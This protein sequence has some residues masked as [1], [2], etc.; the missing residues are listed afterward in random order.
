MRNLTEQE[1]QELQKCRMSPV[2]FLHNYGQILDP[3]LGK[4][5]FHL[6]EYQNICLSKFLENPLN[7]ILKSRQ[8]G[9]SWL[10]AGY[11]LWLSMFFIDK[12][13]LMISIKDE[14]AKGLLN[15]VYYIWRHLPDF[16]QIEISD[17]NMSLIR[18]CTGS[19]IKSVPTS[20]E[21][22][23]SE[24][25]SLL[26]MDE[27]A[28]IR[29]IEQIWAAAYP[30]LS[31]GGQCIV[32]STPN[33]MGN[34][35]YELWNDAIS[36]KNFFN[37][38]R[39]NWWYH[40]ERDAE[41]YDAQRANMSSVQFAQEVIGDFI[42]SGNLVFDVDSLRA[43]QEECAMQEVLER[44][45]TEEFH[46]KEKCG[47]YIYEQARSN[48]DYIMSID[49]AAGGGSGDLHAAH[50][51]AMST[52]VQVAEYQS[53]APIRL[54]N[55]RALALGTKYNYALA[56]PEV[57]QGGMGVP[58]LFHFQDNYYP[59]IYQYVNPLKQGT[60]TPGFPTNSLTRPLLIEEL[61]TSIREGVSGVRGIR[62]ANQLL[63]FAWSKKNKPEAMQGH[64]DDLVM[65]Y[66]IG[67]YVRKTAS[68]QG[69]LPMI[70]S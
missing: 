6:Y 62:T 10:V 30:T 61:D 7:I 3:Y 35:Y 56:A 38:I 43:L 31:T 40:P 46:P 41:W 64:H 36:G 16:L 9:L 50:I 42:A 22:G 29:W 23:R 19:E 63:S 47:L 67:R 69:S 49:T 70:V 17:K 4:I 60:S 65:S 25:L 27:A 39:L 15:K 66:G 14:T 21:A 59:N 53:N 20:E 57:I 48:E 34:F 54:F 28:Y 26:I 24:A 52:G 55:D 13:T 44:H 33:G 45:Y 58:T 5:P 51:I 8:M 2:Y 18:F 12:K 1:F 68:F 32:L 11:A 37:P